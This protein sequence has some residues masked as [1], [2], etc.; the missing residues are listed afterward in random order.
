MID[1]DQALESHEKAN[2]IMSTG[3]FV[4]RGWDSYSNMLQTMFAV[5]FERAKEAESLS[6]AREFLGSN[7]DGVTKDNL[8]TSKSPT[9][10]SEQFEFREKPLCNVA[11]RF[12]DPTGT[13]KLMKLCTT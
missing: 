5:E 2:D 4:L 9:V 3:G 12:W 6:T 10:V 7:I 13:T 11:L 8:P 1:D